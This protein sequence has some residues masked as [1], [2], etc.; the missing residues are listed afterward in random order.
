M[1][2]RASGEG[3]KN[4]EKTRVTCSMLLLPST[5]RQSASLFSVFS[6]RRFV[7]RRVRRV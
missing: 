4:K 3:K 1:R 6:L 2:R 7:V 5:L